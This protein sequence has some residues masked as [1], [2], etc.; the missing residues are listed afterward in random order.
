M[1]YHLIIIGSDYIEGTRIAM[2]YHSIEPISGTDIMYDYKYIQKICGDDIPLAIHK[3]ITDSPDWDSVVKK[4]MFF[5]D[6]VVADRKE[7]FS[8]LLRKSRFISAN[9]LASFIL[10]IVPCSKLKLQ[11][12]VYLCYADFLVKYD[13]KLFEEKIYAFKYGPF[14]KEIDGKYKTRGKEKI[15]DELYEFTNSEIP[16]LLA[17]MVFSKNGKEIVNSCL[18]TIGKYAD[19]SPANLINITHTKGGPW[20]RTYV[21]NKRYL[22][23]T[24]ECIKKYHQFETI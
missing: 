6:I 19:K 9:D 8:A 23:I 18:L 10:S 14:I 20:D 24:D 22:E 5:K 4:D 1:F 12:L 17:R 2:H 21:V 16:P 7:A 15:K 11:K 3:L 13:M